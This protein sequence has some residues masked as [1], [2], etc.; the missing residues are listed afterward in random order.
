MD[1]RTFPTTSELIVLEHRR[2]S[3][4]FQCRWSQA[5]AVAV[6]LKRHY[7]DAGIF[8]H[9]DMDLSFC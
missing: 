4:Y 7:V 5:S 8:A 3:S 6:G 9:C 1:V 2:V